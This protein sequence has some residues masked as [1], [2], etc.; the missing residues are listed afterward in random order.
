MA[1]GGVVGSGL[2]SSVGLGAVG[3]AGGG[4]DGEDAGGG[5]VDGGVT[6]A[7]AVPVWV[8][9]YC[10]DDAIWVQVSTM[11]P[12]FGRVPGTVGGGGKDM[13]GSG[14]SVGRGG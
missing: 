14:G 7:G 1:G 5:T 10:F 6:G 12:V 3:E 8:Q 13:V 4:D 2:P 11:L 9:R